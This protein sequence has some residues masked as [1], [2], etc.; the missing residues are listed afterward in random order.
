M[1]VNQMI[2]RKRNA[3]FN[4]ADDS[5]KQ[6]SRPQTS[7]E[8]EVMVGNVEDLPLLRHPKRVTPQIPGVGHVLDSCS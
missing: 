7:R 5:A 8:D 4:T 1:R 3:T 2:Q 6:Q